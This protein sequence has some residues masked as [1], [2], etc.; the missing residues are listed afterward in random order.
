VRLPLYPLVDFLARWPGVVW[1]CVFG[2]ALVILV[3]HE[4]SQVLDPFGYG[5]P[6]ICVRAELAEGFF[7]G[8]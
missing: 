5:E 7:H 2:G 6:E 3:L 1:L 8:D 4:V